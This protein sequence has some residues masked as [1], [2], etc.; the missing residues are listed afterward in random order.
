MKPNTILVTELFYSLQGEGLF[1]GVP[2]IFLRLFGCNFTCSGFGMPSGK[3]STEHLYVRPLDHLKLSTVPIVKTGCDSF[4]SWD[5]RFKHLSKEYT[6]DQIFE[7]IKTLLPHGKFYREHLI[8]TGGEPLLVKNA[9]FL[10]DFIWDKR[11]RQLKGLTFETNGTQPL[12]KP[13]KDLLA[14]RN[15][16]QQDWLTFSVSPKLP[17]SGE[18]WEVAIK[19]EII[20]QYQEVGTVYLKFVVKDENDL[21]FLGKALKEYK[22]AGF[23]GEVYLMPLGGHLTEHL[24]NREKVAALALKTGLRYSDRLQCS[25]WKNKWGT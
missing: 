11:L 19:P 22:A 21:P 20:N 14:K 3:K 9:S 10:C 1:T 2:S 15:T 25:L 7:K 5:P 13:L 24:K 17:N 12:S 18:K 6:I 16:F 4:T 8:L 23:S